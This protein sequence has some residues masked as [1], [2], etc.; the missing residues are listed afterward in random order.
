MQQIHQPMKRLLMI[1]MMLCVTGLAAKAQ[2][3]V[4]Q[5]IRITPDQVPMA[6]KQTYEKDFSALPEDGYWMV[7]TETTQE[8]RRTATKPIWYSYH[9]RSKSERIEDRFLPNGALE[10]AK[11]ID[12][13][14]FN[15]SD[16]VSLDSDRKKVGTD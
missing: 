15:L 12:R 3:P 16:S 4:K 14:K 10:S 13:D 6:V 11:G 9:K 2:T 5:T 7:Y 1:A 8:G